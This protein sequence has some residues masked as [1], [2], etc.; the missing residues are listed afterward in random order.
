MERHTAPNALLSIY[1][2]SGRLH[3]LM[4]FLLPTRILCVTTTTKKLELQV[5]YDATPK[6]KTNESYIATT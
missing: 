1:H 5:T 6:R 2:S 4:P 3:T